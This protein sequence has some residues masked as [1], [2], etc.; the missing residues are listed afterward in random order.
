MNRRRMPR[1]RQ[2][3]TTRRVLI[4]NRETFYSPNGME[5][6]KELARLWDGTQDDEEIRNN[7]QHMRPAELFQAWLEYEGIIGYSSEIIER[8]RESGYIVEVPED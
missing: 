7:L 8:L 6:R 2:Q 4:G 1:N 3:E 5:M